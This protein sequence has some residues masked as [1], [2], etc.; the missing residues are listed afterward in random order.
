MKR[1]SKNQ[2]HKGR[3]V[4]MILTAVALFA[5]LLYFG[6]HSL[7][8]QTEFEG[9]WEPHL[10][11]DADKLYQYAINPEIGSSCSGINPWITEG[12]YTFNA[13]SIIKTASS[14]FRFK[15]IEVPDIYRS[16]DNKCATVFYKVEVY[17]NDQLIDTISYDDVASRIHAADYCAEPHTAINNRAY[18]D[19]GTIYRSSVA[20]FAIPP[21]GEIV[22]LPEGK[23]GVEVNFGTKSWRDGAR[24]ECRQNHVFHRYNVVYPEDTVEFDA[25]NFRV[26][27]N[28]V[29]FDITATNAKQGLTGDIVIHNDAGLGNP[30]EIYRIKGQSLQLG[31]NELTASLPLT[32]ND[33]VLDIIPKIEAYAPT[34]D[35]SNL[36]GVK[37]FGLTRIQGVSASANT[38]YKIGDFGKQ[39]F[40][41]RIVDGNIVALNYTE[42]NDEIN[43]TRVINNTEIINV[44]QIINET[45]TLTC[46]E[47]GCP[48]NYS[49]E[50][51]VCVLQSEKDTFWWW[52]IGGV[53]IMALIL[54][55][56]LI[57]ILKNRK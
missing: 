42:V 30:F 19:D 35:L 37:I 50:N 15:T 11:V 34:S 31:Q 45:T 47:L 32:K 49:C 53:S 6:F 18:A 46:E 28:S 44:T 29:V 12:G 16:G 21:E 2:T 36:N 54:I 4:I 9:T 56:A 27:N 20:D 38:K 5:A 3:N 17:K 55:I 14:T 10:T 43:N 22:K 23:S 24:V 41:L 13:E 40:T 39:A 57:R 52:A 33:V 7:L 48:D 26:E 1:K 25:K 51:K 8:E